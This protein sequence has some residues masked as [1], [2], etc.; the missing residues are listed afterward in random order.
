MGRSRI[1]APA[2]PMRGQE[3]A[4]RWT[5]GRSWAASRPHEGSGAYERFHHVGS[6]TG[7]A[8]TM[9]GQEGPAGLPYTTPSGTSRPYE[10]SGV[11]L[12]APGRD[13]LKGQPSP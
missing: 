7:P 12:G 9:K 1:P 6:T 3:L 13:G 8:V 2:V 11:G 4:P 5:G 10:G